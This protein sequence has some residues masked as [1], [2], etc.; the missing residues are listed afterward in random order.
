MNVEGQTV[1]EAL[2]QFFTSYPLAQG[3][4]L[5]EQGT[6][7]PHMV[8]FVNGQPIQDRTHLTDALPHQA[9]IHVMQALSGG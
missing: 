6:L 2:Q 4:I 8:I 3:Y 9:E 5:T 7:R 1:G